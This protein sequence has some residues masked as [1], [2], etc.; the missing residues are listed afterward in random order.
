MSDFEIRAIEVHSVYAWDYRWIVKVLEF[1]HKLGLNTLVLHRNDIVDQVVF[2]GF[3]F[4]VPEGKARN[5]FERYD[6]AYRKIYKYTPTRRSGPQLRRDYLRRVTAKASSLGIQVYLQNKELFFPDVLLELFPELTKD[7]HVCACDPFWE[8]FLRTKYTELLED[9]PDI[10]GIITSLGT[11]ESRVSIT[12]NRCTCPLCK[13]KTNEAWYLGLLGAMYEPLAAKGKRLVVRDFVFTKKNQDQLASQF[14]KLPAD[15]AIA[16]KNT[17]HDY[18]PT[19]PNNKLI[20]TLKGRDKW[21]EF[22]AMAQ[23][24]GWGIGPSILLKDFRNRFA[25]AQAQDAKGIILRTDW[26]SLDGHTAFDTPNIVNLYAGAALAQSGKATDE[27]IVRRW[28]EDAGGFFSSDLSDSIRQKATGW[29]TGIL[30]RSWEVI[31]QALFI[32]D[33]VFNDCS[34]FP[35]GYEQALW[36]TIEKNSLQDWMP[37]KAHV[38]DANDSAMLAVI[39]E[40]TNAFAQARELALAVDSCPE[41]YFS[42]A[43]SS[44]LQRHFSFNVPYI[45][46]FSALGTLFAILRFGLEAGSLSASLGDRPLEERLKDAV[47]EIDS[48]VAEYR[49]FFSATDLPHSFYQLLSADK[50][51]CFRD[52]AVAVAKERLGWKP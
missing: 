48:V 2:P 49:D 47:Q 52:D 17:P 9:V 40:K 36:L 33:C 23:Y 21:I 34:T 32:Q 31:R 29:L 16:I 22:D 44:F 5:I 43:F 3:V 27:E 14:D 8:S 15:V 1:A 42:P 4:G 45:R 6:N 19:F 30:R 39:E 10:A 18:Y 25:H 46:G 41:G 11:G 12:S 37:S 13:S 38:Y 28:I 26:E 50:L 7:G 20:E 35:V 24:F 51:Q